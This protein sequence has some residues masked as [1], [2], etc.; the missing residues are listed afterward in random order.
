MAEETGLTKYKTEPQKQQRKIHI[1]QSPDGEG[2]LC[3]TGKKKSDRKRA[4][5]L[6]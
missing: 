1:V 6:F 4:I 3:L 5:C 2:S